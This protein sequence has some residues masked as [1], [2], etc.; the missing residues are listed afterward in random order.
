LEVIER[1]SFMK[2]VYCGKEIEEGTGKTVNV[3]NGVFDVCSNECKKAV[4]DY[5]V[6]DQKYKKASYLTIFCGSVGFIISTFLMRG[7]FKLLPMYIG[8]IIVGLSFII[9]PYVFQNF[10]TFRKHCI[11]SLTRLVRIIGVVIILVAIGFILVT[12]V[13]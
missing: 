9:I 10:I 13:I 3:S 1:N 11:V 8:M 5:L 2:C 4:K 7:E 6:Q 12:W